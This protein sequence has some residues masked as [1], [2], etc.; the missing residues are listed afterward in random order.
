M[1]TQHATTNLNTAKNVAPE[2]GMGEMGEARFMRQ[3]LG[4]ERIGLSHY[5]MNPGRRVGFG[6]RHTESEEVYVVLAGS[7][8]FKVE[9]EIID[10]AVK[11]VVYCPPAAMREWEAG[12]DGLELLAF[13]GH[14]ENE[15]ELKRGWWTD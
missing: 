15:S 1:S 8:R 11:D 7:G 6:H 12:P 10:I 3:A 13:G 4:A 2:Y 9:D 5:R 14:A